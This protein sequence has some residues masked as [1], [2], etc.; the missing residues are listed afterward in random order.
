MKKLDDDIRQALAYYIIMKH[1]IEFE[2]FFGPL[3]WEKPFKVRYY[4]YG[5]TLALDCVVYGGRSFGKSITLE[6]NMLQ[7]ALNCYNE[8]SLLTTFRRM[9]IKDRFE[10]VIAYLQKVLYFRKFMKGSAD[11]TTKDSVT[12]TPFYDIHL[13]NGHALKGISVGDDP[14]AVAIQGTH[15]TLRYIDECQMYPRE[16][17]VKFQSTRDPR[18]SHDKFF[19]CTDGRISTP[20][21]ELEKSKRFK[22][23]RFHVPRLAEPYFNQEDKFNLVQTFGSE[24][25]NDYLQQVLAQHGEPAWSVWPEDSIRACI[26]KT[27]VKQGSGILSHRLQYITISSKDYKNK[28]VA[29]HAFLQDLKLPKGVSDIIL[30]IDAGYSEPTVILPFFHI[31]HKWYLYT[32]IELIDRMIPD[33][34]TEIIDYIADF[35]NTMIIPIDCS[36]A[37]G[38]AVASSLQNPKREEY[39]NKNYD[40]RVIWVEFQKYFEVGKRINETTKEEEIIKERVKEK[41][42][43]LLR[44]MFANQ[45]FHLYYSEDLLVQFNAESQRRSATGK[46]E[47]I[48]PSNVHIPEAFRCFAAAYFQKYMVVK[49][50]ILEE[51]VDDM[52]HA[53]YVELGFNV[54]NS[55]E[56][57]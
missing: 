12:R 18:G 15:P 42:T 39:K 52:A 9:H 44:Q 35:Y 34:Q 17:W 36:S 38:R 25:S 54:F 16:A 5:Y 43:T 1:K 4:Q 21:Y 13:R 8:E 27:E 28:S 53:E 11:K 2:N 3:A 41:T 6:F 57:E 19:G 31:N 37:D 48:T 20:Y 26:D 22:N 45:D 24:N 14:L 46:V 51:E 7:N 32:I 10:K 50:E 56:N 30:A 33:D 23:K 49:E 55:N 47:I 29:P 40:K